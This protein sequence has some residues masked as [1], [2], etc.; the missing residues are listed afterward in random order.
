M[1]SGF[2]QIPVSTEHKKALIEWEEIYKGIKPAPTLTE[3]KKKFKKFKARKMKQSEGKQ[4]KKASKNN[5]C[6]CTELYIL[7]TVQ[8]YTTL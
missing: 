1:F 8:Y 2:V 3:I 5:F 4:S 6:H 7:Y